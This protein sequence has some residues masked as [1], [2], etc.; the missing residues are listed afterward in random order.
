MFLWFVKYNEQGIGQI[1]NFSNWQID[2]QYFVLQLFQDLP[3]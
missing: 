1:I 3:F 2:K